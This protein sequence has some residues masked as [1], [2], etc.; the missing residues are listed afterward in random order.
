MRIYFRFPVV[1]AYKIYIH[2]FCCMPAARVLVGYKI[3]ILIFCFIEI[4]IIHKFM[5]V[6]VWAARARQ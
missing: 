5:F 2:I 1:N 3:F 4:L 6:Y